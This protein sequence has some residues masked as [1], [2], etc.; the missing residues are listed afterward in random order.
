MKADFLKTFFTTVTDVHNMMLDFEY[1]H[2]RCHKLGRMECNVLEYLQKSD[3]PL[4]MKE[5]AK[6]MDVSYSRITNLIDTLLEKTYIERITSETDRRVYLAQVTE[7]GMMVL[8]KCKCRR[9]KLYDE[10]INSYPED[11]Q[12]KILESFENWK[13]FLVRM[14]NEVGDTGNIPKKDK[15]KV[16][17]I[18]KKEQ[19]KRDKEA[20]R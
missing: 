9:I 16:E 6:N 2:K 8:E 17:K 4:T 3:R 7:E 18:K 20:Y 19:A 10:F 1:A 12:V 15:V 11:E 5:I 14:K 13:Q